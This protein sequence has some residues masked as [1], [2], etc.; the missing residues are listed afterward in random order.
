MNYEYSEEELSEF[1]DTTLDKIRLKYGLGK[2][3][4]DN[5]INSIL[6]HQDYL[7]STVLNKNAPVD[8]IK[9]IAINLPPAAVINLCNTNKRH[10]AV[11]CRDK[12]FQKDYGLKYLT[13]DISKFP[14]DKQ[15]NYKVI[16]ELAKLED[17]PRKI[18]IHG[19][20]VYLKNNIGNFDNFNRY[21]IFYAAVKNG[22]LDMMKYLV[23]E[24][25]HITDNK[26]QALRMAAEYG[27]LEVAKYLVSEGANVD[28]P[29][30]FLN[31]LNNNQ[32][33]TLDYLIS[34]GADPGLYYP[35]W[36]AVTNGEL[37]EVKRLVSEGANLDSVDSFDINVLQWASLYG[38]LDMVK[39]L[40]SEGLDPVQNV[41]P[42]AVQGGNL[43]LVKY[44]AQEAPAMRSDLVDAAKHGHIDIVKYLESEL[45]MN[46]DIANYA[47]YWAA[48]NGHLRIVKYLVSKYPSYI[49]NTSEIASPVSAAS[50]KGYLEIVKYLISKGAN[51]DQALPAAAQYG[52][53]KVVKY[54]ILQ[55]V[56]P[57]VINYAFKMAAGYEQP[58]VVK[59]LLSLGEDP[60]S[61]G[62]TDVSEYMLNYIKKLTAELQ[63]K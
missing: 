53:L 9:S 36:K 39:Y 54:L 62:N 44:L 5:L 37:E 4:R 26:N 31:A 8:I 57:R 10:N 16:Q 35:L 30:A 52:Q 46:N 47:I 1:P 61:L 32:F 56:G 38:Q 28:E 60:K 27:Q 15:G 33:E 43:E 45:V 42:M 58:E 41:L 34:R 51:P 21:R 23:S 19:Y 29:D 63:K 14:V 6:D 24:G 50:Q 11:L 25:I 22:H 20:E 49:K 40:I 7:E 13:K 59:Y 2:Q 55:G 18:G 3:N 17:E 12:Y 48:T